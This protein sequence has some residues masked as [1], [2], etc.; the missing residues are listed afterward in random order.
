[1]IGK[2]EKIKK[3]IVVIVMV[4][5]A[6]EQVYEIVKEQN[7]VILVWND[8]IFASLKTNGIF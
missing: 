3:S 1:M 8:E 5:K 7:L 2:K 6:E 4:V